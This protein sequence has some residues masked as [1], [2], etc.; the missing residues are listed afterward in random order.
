MIWPHGFIGLSPLSTG[1]IATESGNSVTAVRNVAEQ[2]CSLQ[3]VWEEVCCGG[4]ER[5]FGPR[6]SL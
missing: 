4:M 6:Y 2:R 1:P 5:G 3:D